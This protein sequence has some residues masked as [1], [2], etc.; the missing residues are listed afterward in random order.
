M[1]HKLEQEGLVERVATPADRRAKTIRLSG[2]WRISTRR[3]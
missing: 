2:C 1:L 3:S